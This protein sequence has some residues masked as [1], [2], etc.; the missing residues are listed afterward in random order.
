M[1]I[2]FWQRCCA[3]HRGS[4]HWYRLSCNTWHAMGE[5]CAICGINR[6]KTWMRLT[7]L[8]Q[9]L[10]FTNLN[11]RILTS[12]R[13]RNGSL[14]E[15]NIHCGK[16][17]RPPGGHSDYWLYWVA[18]TRVPSLPLRVK[19]M[20]CFRVWEFLQRAV[21]PNLANGC[22]WWFMMIHVLQTDSCDKSEAW[23]TRIHRIWWSHLLHQQNEWL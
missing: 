1:R 18:V 20:L 7:F 22:K 12:F 19:R 15:K 6:D 5:V 3:G 11:L 13:T 14:N 9:N 10:G 17:I 23:F 4:F 21:E 8:P 16:I 2:P